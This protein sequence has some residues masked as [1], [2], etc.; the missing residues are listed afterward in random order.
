MP[1]LMTQKDFLTQLKAEFPELE[2]WDNKLLMKQIFERRPD[3]INKI[4]N[5]MSGDVQAA[6]AQK[7]ALG[8]SH[9][10]ASFAR[11]VTSSF[12]GIGGIVGGMAGPGSIMGVPL[13]VGAGRGLQDITNQ[14]LGI[15]STT[16]WEKTGNIGKDVGL[17][18]AVPAG[19]EML[20]SP[21]KATKQI[22]SDTAGLAENL[23]DYLPFSRYFK[24]A[25][26]ISDLLRPKSNPPNE[27][28]GYLERPPGYRVGE[29][30]KDTSD[31]KL[32]TETGSEVPGVPRAD[33]LMRYPK[34]SSTTMTIQPKPLFKIVV[35]EKGHN[36]LK[37]IEE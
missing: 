12:P 1:K 14:M 25:K 33:R 37:R 22:L 20:K 28:G 21:I 13:G 15:D 19:I 11:A 16:P 9:E 3:L 8:K 10:D 27:M 5:P 24:P 17:A 34:S 23:E 32:Q 6:Q 36:I 35:D 4:E 18:M 7:R 2:A 26:K 30:L 31:I 29:P